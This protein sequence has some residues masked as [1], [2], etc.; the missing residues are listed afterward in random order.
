M[1]DQLSKTIHQQRSKTLP[2]TKHSL[3]L[4]IVFILKIFA[5]NQFYPRAYRF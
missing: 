2:R 5:T 4:I 1:I 3:T